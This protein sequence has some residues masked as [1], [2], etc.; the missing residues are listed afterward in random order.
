MLKPF[1]DIIELFV[2][3]VVVAIIVFL[4]TRWLIMLWTGKTRSEG[5]KAVW[6][7]VNRSI[8]FFSSK[9]EYHVANDSYLA[10]KVWQEIGAVIGPKRFHTLE[11][12]SLLER[13]SECGM[14]GGLPFIALTVNCHETEKA[15]IEAIVR[16]NIADGL[17]VHGHKNYVLVD[18]N[19]N[20]RLKMPRIVARFAE[21]VEQDKIM[22]E[23]LKR[24]QERIIKR[25]QSIHDKDIEEFED[26]EE[27]KTTDNPRR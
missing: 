1:I 13:V 12:L 20:P 17:V 25:N 8:R 14:A 23:I 7:I 3:L 15:M 5:T 21:N 22:R 19:E 11:K 18:W 26:D 2:I 6:A 4:L 10:G 27:D 9:E 16:S 24:E